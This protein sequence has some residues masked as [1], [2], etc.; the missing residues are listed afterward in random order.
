M[1]LKSS[2]SSQTFNL[3]LHS[4]GGSDACP[5]WLDQVV[6]AALPTSASRHNS[7][8]HPHVLNKLVCSNLPGGDVCIVVS[9]SYVLFDFIVK[10]CYFSSFHSLRSSADSL[11]LAYAYLISRL[12]YIK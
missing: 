6:I 4:M 12:C 5:V 7:P 11:Q 2:S 9:Y 3:V 8:A 1:I 10:L